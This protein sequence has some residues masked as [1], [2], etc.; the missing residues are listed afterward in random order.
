MF[1]G[2]V[3]NGLSWLPLISRIVWAK[4]PLDPRD[5][6]PLIF[7]KFDLL[8]YLRIVIATHVSSQLQF[9]AQQL[10]E[11]A[12]NCNSLFLTPGVGGGGGG[13]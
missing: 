2:N 9:N 10:P 11:Y 1:K 13:R 12:T 3:V 6:A 8:P 7:S 4:N 5:R